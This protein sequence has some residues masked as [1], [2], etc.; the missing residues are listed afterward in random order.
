MSKPE[1]ERITIDSTGRPYA[2]VIAAIVDHPGDA[3]RIQL[4]AMNEPES[5]RFL[6]GKEIRYEVDPERR[7]A[8][9]LADDL[10]EGEPATIGPR[11]EIDD[12]G[13]VSFHGPV[14]VEGNLSIR[15]GAIEF[16][17]QTSV[18]DKC[19]PKNPAIY[20]WVEEAGGSAVPA[21]PSEDE[22]SALIAAAIVSGN[23]EPRDALRINLGSIADGIR[24]L[25][26]GFIGDD[27]KFV[28]CLEVKPRKDPRPGA[29]VTINGDLRVQGTLNAKHID[30]LRLSEDAR[31]ALRAPFLAG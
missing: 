8:I 25:E 29:T 24:L 12:E 22:G 21:A 11:F 3:S 19:V 13:E 27:G 1:P 14:Q 17:E 18:S 7:F 20:R 15:N 26:I 31:N 4:G 9:F 16:V 5:V 30:L 23:T 10:V 28:T 6:D 2:G